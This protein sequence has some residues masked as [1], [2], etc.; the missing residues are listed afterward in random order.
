[1][2]FGDGAEEGEGVAGRVGLLVGPDEPGQPVAAEHIGRHPRYVGREHAGGVEGLADDGGPVG[3][4]L[5]EGLAGPVPGD[6]DAPAA[7]AEVLP[8]V[9]L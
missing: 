6:E 9:R 7:D 1:V 2:P 4:V 3:S 8:I 5:S